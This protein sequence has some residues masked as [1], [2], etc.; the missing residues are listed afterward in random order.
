MDR[1]VSGTPRYQVAHRG[2]LPRF[3]PRHIN[4]MNTAT[5]FPWPGLAEAEKSSFRSCFEHFPIAVARCNSEGVI[6]EMNPACER[7]LKNLAGG[8]NL[9]LVELVPAPEREQLESQL[10]ELL[11]SRRDRIGIDAKGTGNGQTIAKWTGWR[12]P[13]RAGEAE[14]A[15]FMVEP[16]TEVGPEESVPQAQRWETIGR[17]A[18]GVVHDFNNLLTGVTLYCVLLLSSLDA[19]DRRRRYADEIRCAIAQASGLVRQLLLGARPQTAS[20]QLQSLNEIAA[21][22]RQLLGRLIGD[23]I[24]LQLQLDPELGAV[25]IDRAQV[26][27]VLLNLVL[28][29]RDALGNGGRITIETSN[30]R[31]QPVAGTTSQNTAPAFPCVLLAVRD[32][33]QGMNAETRGRLFEPFFTT[34][35]AGQ[36]GGLGLTIL[37]SI[38]TANHGLIHFESEAGSGTRAMI[39]FPRSCDEP[40]SQ[41]RLGTDSGMNLET[42]LPNLKKESLL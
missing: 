42:P 3:V 13:G 28:N 23:N 30:C 22:M 26:E 31:F 39:L 8:R 9:R 32:D 29:A 38:V 33:G 24:I 40:D 37:R 7:S 11:H 36:G 16:R 10:H 6:V 27:Q 1:P 41:A 4:N 21:A 19:R 35:A 18:G 25:R 5:P 2:L 14:H 34:K 15:L 12:Q 20:P 17:M